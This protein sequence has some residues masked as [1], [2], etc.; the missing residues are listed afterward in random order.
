ML[1]EGWERSG[2]AVCLG[3]MESEV[4]GPRLGIDCVIMTALGLQDPTWPYIPKGILNQE[5]AFAWPTTREQISCIGKV[6][7]ILGDRQDQLKTLPACLCNPRLDF[8]LY[9]ILMWI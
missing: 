1:H 4:K 8:S 3:G 2:L 5:S 9:T 7:L 6:H